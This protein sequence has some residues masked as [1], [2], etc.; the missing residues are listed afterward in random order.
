MVLTRTPPHSQDIDGYISAATRG[1]DDENG[2]EN[3]DSDDRQQPQQK[4][5]GSA[6]LRR[7]MRTLNYVA[8]VLSSTIAGS[9]Y[10]SSGGGNRKLGVGSYSPT[11]FHSLK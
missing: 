5:D 8:G 10:V 7:E 6:A 2:E 1:G 3:G 9:C 4:I 11:L